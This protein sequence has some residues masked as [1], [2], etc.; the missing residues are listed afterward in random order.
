MVRRHPD[1]KW[2]RREPDIQ[3]FAVQ[4]AQILGALW[5]CLERGG[6]LLYVTCSVFEEENGAQIEAFL[7]QNHDAK[8]L[9]LE[10]M[11][12]LDGQLIPNDQHDGFYYA[13]LAK[14]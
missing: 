1:I 11:G 5:Q 3:K 2:L 4:Q 12:D 13:L 9:P 7:K 14:D 6:K 8:R 10:G